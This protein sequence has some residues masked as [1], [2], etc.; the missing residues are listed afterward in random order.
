M[1]H[2]YNIPQ[3]TLLI[4]RRC[5]SKVYEPRLHAPERDIIKRN[6]PIFV[7]DSLYDDWEEESDLERSHILIQTLDK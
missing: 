3:M 1:R 4:N 5:L 7:V 6:L 2:K